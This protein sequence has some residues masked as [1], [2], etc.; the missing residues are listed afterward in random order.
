MSA[1]GPRPAPRLYLVTDRHATG[2]RPLPDVIAAALRGIA[3]AG[4]P[5]AEVAVQLREKDLSGRALMALARELR[6]ITAAAG[7]ALYVNDRVD[8]ACAVGADGVHLGAASLPPARV[9]A[10]VPGLA[11]GIS[12]HAASEVAAARGGGASGD[13]ADPVSFA[14]LGPIYDTPSKRSFGA[15][16]GEGALAAAARAGLPVLAIGGVDVARVR[17]LVRAGARGVACI[18]PVMSAADPA[19][20]TRAFCAELIAT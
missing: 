12:T 18:R 6:A 15:P 11:I 1:D 2:G 7:V 17:A 9:A 19:A 10:T 3:G 14:V 8:V 5:P 13:T 20:A 16:L 4:L